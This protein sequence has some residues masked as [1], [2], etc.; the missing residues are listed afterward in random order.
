MSGGCPARVGARRGPPRGS[1]AAR[2]HNK[3]LQSREQSGAIRE[4]TFDARGGR[5]GRV[6]TGPER[7][8]RLL[9]SQTPGRNAARVVTP[10]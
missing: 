2:E 9:R 4:G 6:D 5:P 10:H 1:R 8:R 3:P 7:S